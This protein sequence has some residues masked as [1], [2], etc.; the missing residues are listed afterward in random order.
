MYMKMFVVSSH[1]Y[2]FSLLAGIA[3]FSFLMMHVCWGSTCIFFILLHV[4]IYLLDLYCYF[5]NTRQ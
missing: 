1:G 3:F 2:M 5:T 4:F